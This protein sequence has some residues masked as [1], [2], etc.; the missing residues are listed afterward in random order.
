M[1][2]LGAALVSATSSLGEQGAGHHTMSCR[3]DDCDRSP[4]G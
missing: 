1:G 4:A 2:W 3:G